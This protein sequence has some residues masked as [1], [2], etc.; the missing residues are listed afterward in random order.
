MSPHDTQ[1]T[2]QIGIRETLHWVMD[3]T[4]MLE[5]DYKVFIYNILIE[6]QFKLNIKTSTYHYYLLSKNNLSHYANYNS[7]T[8]HDKRKVFTRIKRKMWVLLD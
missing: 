4:N 3:I 8:N 2:I 6:S 5:Q 1:Q 7:W